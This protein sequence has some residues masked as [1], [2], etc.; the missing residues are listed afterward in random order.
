MNIYIVIVIYLHFLN[1]PRQ[2]LRTAAPVTDNVSP[3]SDMMQLLS[4]FDEWISTD[5]TDMRIL[6]KVKD[7]R[8]H[9]RFRALAQVQR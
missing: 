6:I 4:P 3:I 5:L 1:V 8:P 2:L 9:L 7:H